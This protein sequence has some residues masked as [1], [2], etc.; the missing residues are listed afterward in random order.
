VTVAAPK[1]LLTTR[2]SPQA[3]HQLAP[4]VAAVLADALAR[5]DVYVIARVADD[6]EEAA[7][8]AAFAPLGID[9]RVKGTIPRWLSPRSSLSLR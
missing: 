6:A 1:V 9:L 5:C 8:R 2:P 7:V 3:P 4:G